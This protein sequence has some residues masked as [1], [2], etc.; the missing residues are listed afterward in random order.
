[1]PLSARRSYRHDLLWRLLLDRGLNS[2]QIIK[3][4]RKLINVHRVIDLT[5]VPHVTREL[6]LVKVRARSE[7]RPEILRI[8]DI[9]RGKVVD[10]SPTEYTI[11]VTG[12]Q[13]KMDAIL[14]L[15][16]RFTVVEIARSGV[17]ALPR[18]KKGD[19]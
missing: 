14:S 17:I 12:D 10:V 18:S 16:T 15:L 4:L 13:E 11:E 5:E 7:D 1:M 2:Q 8:V 6:A 3:Q 19:K 9:F